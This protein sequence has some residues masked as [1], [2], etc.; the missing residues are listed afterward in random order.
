MH[1]IVWFETTCVFVVELRLR[2]SCSKLFN[3]WINIYFREICLFILIIPPIYAQKRNR[4]RKWYTYQFVCMLVFALSPSP[5][6]CIYYACSLWIGTI[7]FY[8]VTRFKKFRPSC[9]IWNIHWYFSVLSEVSFY[10][11][12]LSLWNVNALHNVYALYKYLNFYISPT[13]SNCEQPLNLKK[14]P[15]EFLAGLQKSG[16]VC[17]PSPVERSNKSSNKDL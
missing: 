4:Q 5:F 6:W 8:I 9:L 12:W 13:L 14:K 2:L 3:S 1:I 15:G 7:L 11:C 10:Q 17:E 16:Y